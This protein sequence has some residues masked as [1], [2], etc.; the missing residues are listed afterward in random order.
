M[1]VG[2]LVKAW[3][4]LPTF[5]L[6]P[7]TGY[8]P[9]M[10]SFLG[11]LLPYLNSQISPRE[12]SRQAETPTLSQHPLQFRHSPLDLRLDPGQGIHDLCRSSV[13]DLFVDD[14]LVP[15]K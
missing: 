1:T 9:G 11:R 3:L 4:W 5:P 15:V 12:I 2:P 6:E 13:F 14:F 8:L 7:Y 10:R